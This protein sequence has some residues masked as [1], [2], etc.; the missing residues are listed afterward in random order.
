MRQKIVDFFYKKKMFFLLALFQKFINGA[1]IINKKKRNKVTYGNA[2]LYKSKIFSGLS[3]NEIAIGDNTFLEKSKINIKGS[4]NHVY[5]GKNSFVC[6]LHLV[7]EGDNNTVHIGDNFF[8]C[9]DVY[10]NVIDGSRFVA[11]DGGMFSTRIHIR[12]SDGHS[13]IDT[14]S[15]QRI[16]YEKDIILHDKVWLGYG[17]TLLKGTE[18]AESCIVGA[19]SVVSKKHLI[20]NSVIVGNPAKEVKNN[21]KWR[22]E[23]I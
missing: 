23:R 7:I 4:N 13:I 10:I 17:V 12:T 9:D 16:N 15:D 3:S 1:K 19:C 20:P 21:V 6:G 5:I 8:I 14:I 22:M 11:G 2:V 18:I